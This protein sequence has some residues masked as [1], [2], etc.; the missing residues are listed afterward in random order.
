MEKLRVSEN[1]WKKW[2]LDRLDSMTLFLS[3]FICLCFKDW[4][5]STRSQQVDIAM[6]STA[7]LILWIPPPQEAPDQLGGNHGTDVIQLDWKNH[8]KPTPDTP[9]P[10]TRS[11]PEIELRLRAATGEYC[12]HGNG[13]KVLNSNGPRT[14]AILCQFY[15]SICQH[16]GLV[17]ELLKRRGC[18]SFGRKH[19]FFARP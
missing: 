7:M 13:S 1:R 15:V 16:E 11:K 10:R 8:E 17:E 6:S 9:G 2:D 12:I 18:F 5:F 3:V 19:V 4:H 14:V